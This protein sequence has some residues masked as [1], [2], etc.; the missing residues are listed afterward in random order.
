MIIVTR[1]RR[2][3]REN[4]D[5][6]EAVLMYSATVVVASHI[7]L[8]LRLECVFILL[9]LQKFQFDLEAVTITPAHFLSEGS[10]VNLEE[11]V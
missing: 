7:K 8:Y 3:S 11:A 4:V 6:R 2:R 1:K 9:E 5:C 10:C